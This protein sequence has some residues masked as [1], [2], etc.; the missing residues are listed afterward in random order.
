MYVLHEC[1]VDFSKPDRVW[2]YQAVLFRLEIFIS[3]GQLSSVLDQV[4][5]RILFAMSFLIA[6]ATQVLNITI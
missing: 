3:V 1:Y 4:L 6:T 5:C 2:T